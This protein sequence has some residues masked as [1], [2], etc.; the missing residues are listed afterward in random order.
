MNF[1]AILIVVILCLFDTDDQSRATKQEQAHFMCGDCFVCI[2]LVCQ[3]DGLEL[4]RRNR[5]ITVRGVAVR[6][7]TPPQDVMW[8][9]S[10]G[11]LG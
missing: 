2:Y 5:R 10:E 4:G 1:M 8:A 7:N 9:Q 11:T 3:C 6:I